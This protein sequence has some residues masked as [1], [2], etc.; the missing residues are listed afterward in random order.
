MVWGSIARVS[1]LASVVDHFSL[2]WRAGR[3]QPPSLFQE[4]SSSNLRLP[5]RVLPWTCLF[6][7]FIAERL[8]EH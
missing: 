2:P 1:G 5:S 4:L 7:H 3:L 6:R 8:S